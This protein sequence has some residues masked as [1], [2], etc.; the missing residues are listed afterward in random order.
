MSSAFKLRQGNIAA[1]I[2]AGV[3]AANQAITDGEEFFNDAVHGAQA[4]M[5]NFAGQAVN[6][7]GALAGMMAGGAPAGGARLQQGDLAED[8]NT[9]NQDALQAFH[10]FDQSFADGLEQ[11]EMITNNVIGTTEQALGANGA[12]VANPD[13]LQQ[14][15]AEAATQDVPDAAG[16]ADE[17]AMTPLEAFNDNILDSILDFG[18]FLNTLAGGSPRDEARLQRLH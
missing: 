18:G 13:R 14:D 17:A 1:D 7:A 8:F 10:D 6:G 16:D 4:T 5:E 15:E 3:G 9:L 11:T 2:G 12:T